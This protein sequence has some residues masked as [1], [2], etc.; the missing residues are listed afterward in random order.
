MMTSWRLMHTSSDTDFNMQRVSVHADWFASILC[1]C[2]CAAICG[3]DWYLRFSLSLA[4]VTCEC[5]RFV[6]TCLHHVSLC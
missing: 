4:V 1:A 2:P 3:K 6:V 5:L